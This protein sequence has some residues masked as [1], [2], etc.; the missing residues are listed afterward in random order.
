MARFLLGNVE[1]IAKCLRE[2]QRGTDPSPPPDIYSDLTFVLFALVEAEAVAFTAFPD[3]RL[4]WFDQGQSVLTSSAKA[5]ELE[6]TNMSVKISFIVTP[7][8][9]H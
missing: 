2:D 1:I 3:A 4:S 7:S 8:E 9:I 6:R 5:M